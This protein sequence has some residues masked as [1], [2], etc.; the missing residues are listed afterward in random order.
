MEFETIA[1][2]T[3]PVGNPNVPAAGAANASVAVCPP[4]SADADLQA[5]VE[6]WPSLPDAIKAGIR[7]MV[8]ASSS[9][10]LAGNDR[11]A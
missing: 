2:G 3:D 5:L 1:N 8:H 11:N 4:V 6:A 10:P 9:G 7:A